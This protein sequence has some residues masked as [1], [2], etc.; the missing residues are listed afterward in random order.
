M[1]RLEKVAAASRR[2]AAILVVWAGAFT[3]SVMFLLLA[4]IQL[5][6]RPSVPRKHRDEEGWGMEHGCHFRFRVQVPGP[7]DARSMAK[8]IGQTA[9][10]VPSL[11]GATM[12]TTTTR[13]LP[14]AKTI[15][16]GVVWCSGP[17]TRLKRE[18]TKRGKRKK[19][20]PKN[21]PAGQL[22]GSGGPHA[23]NCSAHVPSQLK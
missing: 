4:A 6:G 16:S 20:K 2:H 9:N 21:P 5:G 19:K 22:P 15:A 17:E 1:D 12:T 14:W 10:E 11:A 3:C 7:L 23:K 18:G 13:G 8:E